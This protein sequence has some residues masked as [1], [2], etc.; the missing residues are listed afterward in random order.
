[1]GAVTRGMLISVNIDLMLLRASLSRLLLIAA[2]T[3][4]TKRIAL[5]P[6]EAVRLLNRGCPG[7]RQSRAEPGGWPSRRRG[8]KR[9]DEQ[10]LTDPDLVVFDITAADEETALQVMAGLER[11]WVTSG[12]AALR[13][14]PGAPWVRARVYA[15]AR[16]SGV[17]P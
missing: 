15:D 9:S 5:R 8:Q 17:E 13:R 3:Y 16:R 1:M 7:E 11:S 4:F 12:R 2:L 6:V 14:T 10:H